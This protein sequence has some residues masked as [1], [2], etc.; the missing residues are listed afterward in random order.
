MTNQYRAV[1]RF[2]EARY[3]TEVFEADFTVAEE[4]DLLD[5][6]ALVIEPRPYRVLSDNYTIEGQPIWR[7]AIVEA[8]FPIEIEQMLVDG[9]HLER[10][11]RDAHP[12]V[13]VEPA[14]D[15]EPRRTTRRRTATPIKE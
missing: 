15:P 3:G 1:S 9:G 2:G 11:R 6:G 13:D 4:L 5:R 14:A 8:G 10:V 7:D 12:T